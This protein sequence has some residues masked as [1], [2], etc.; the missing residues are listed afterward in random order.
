MRLAA[1]ATAKR[2]T[3][4]IQ[5]NVLRSYT[6]RVTLADILGSNC[7]GLAIFLQFW[8]ESHSLRAQVKHIPPMILHTHAAH[9]IWIVAPLD[10][11][12]EAFKPSN[13]YTELYHDCQKISEIK[14]LMNGFANEAKNMDRL[15]CRIRN[16]DR[17]KQEY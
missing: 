6:L 10:C 8:K 15:I 4:Y 14:W 17:Y 9:M 2:A 7:L 16:A 11:L 3:Y 12:F 13:N 1:R 5:L